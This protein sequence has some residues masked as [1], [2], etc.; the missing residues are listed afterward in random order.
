MSTVEPGGELPVGAPGPTVLRMMLGNQLH[1]L[2]EAAGVTPEQAGYEIRASRSK[3]RQDLL[4][5]P[6]PPRVW[7][8]IDE[9]ALRRRRPSTTPTSSPSGPP[10]RRGSCTST[11]MRSC[12]PKPAPC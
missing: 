11:T 6:D 3:M 5:S 1:Q 2:R 9:A 7:S 8:V 4:T 12:W 10:R